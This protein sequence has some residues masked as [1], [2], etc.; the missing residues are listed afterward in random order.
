MQLAS[1]AEGEKVRTAARNAVDYT[2]HGKRYAPM[3]RRW[4]YNNVL[5]LYTSDYPPIM[6]GI[7]TGAYSFNDDPNC[8]DTARNCLWWSGGDQYKGFA[9]DAVL[10]GYPDLDAI[11]RDL[12]WNPFFGPIELPEY[13]AGAYPEQLGRQVP[14]L[15]ERGT[16]SYRR[17][18][19]GQEARARLPREAERAVAPR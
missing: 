1:H 15:R 19:A 3:R 17:G 8:P 14:A 12:D 10:S 5:E 7:L 4:Q 16:G 9:L 2:Y 6:F 13:T 11:A 18:C